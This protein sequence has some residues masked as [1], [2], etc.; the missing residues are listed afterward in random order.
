MQHTTSYRIHSVAQNSERD[1]KLSYYRARYYDQT[2]GRFFGEDPIDFQGGIDFYAYV[3]SRPISFS[4]P[5]G[6]SPLSSCLGTCLKIYYGL[7]R[8][9]GVILGITAP[10]IPKAV[11]LGGGTGGTSVASII[12]RKVLPCKIPRI[13]APTIGSLG[14]RTAVL[15]GAVARWLPLIG[16]GLLAVDA[17]GIQDCTRQCER[18]NWFPQPPACSGGCPAH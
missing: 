17:Y 10:I 9:A 15:G 7:T 8:D 16:Y 12:L 13:A 5:T 2:A 18:D 6:L 4:D 14:A 1:Q 3:S 11:V